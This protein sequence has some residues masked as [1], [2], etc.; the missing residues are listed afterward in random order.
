YITNQPVLGVTEGAGELG[1]S[2]LAAGGLGND[3]KLAVNVPL[4]S[5]AA[6]RVA[7]YNTAIGGFVDAVQPDLSVRENVDGG[8]RTGARAAVLVQPNEQI[9]L[10]PQLV[11]QDVSMNGWNRMDAY[12]ILA[13]PFT[14]TRPAVSL[15]DRQ[16]FT[17]ID[18]PYT[19]RFVL[20]DL[21]AEID[22][23]DV[24]LTQITS[25][26]YRDVEVVRDASALGASVSFSPFGAPEAGYTLDVPLVDATTAE[27][28]TQEIRLAGG[29]ERLD[30]LFGSFY[31]SSERRYGQS[32][33]AK[34]YV[35]VNGPAVTN[36]LRAVTGIPDLVSSGSRPLAGHPHTRG[37]VLLRP[38]LRLRAAR[39]L[40]RGDC[41]RHRPA[42]PDRRPPLERLRRGAHP[43][44]RR[45]LRR[46]PRQRR[47]DVSERDRTAN[48]RQHDVTD[49]TQVNAQVSKGFRL[50]GING[51]LNAPIC[52]EADLATFGSRGPWEDEELW[53]CEA[54]VKS[55]SLGGRG[56]FKRLR[57]LYGHPQPAGDPHGPA[58][59][60][61]ASSST[62]PTRA[63]PGVK[64]ELAA[65]PATFFDFAVSASLADARL[66]STITSTDAD[67]AVGVVSGI[68]TGRRLPSTHRF[69]AAAAAAWR[70]LA[71]G[72]WVGYLSG[73]G[74]LPPSIAAAIS[75]PIFSRASRTGAPTLRMYRSLITVVL[76]PRRSRKTCVP[77]PARAAAVMVVL[78]RSCN[79]TSSSP[80]SFAAARKLRCAVWY[81][82]GTVPFVV[83]A[84]GPSRGIS[85][86]IAS[87]G[88]GRS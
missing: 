52:S 72:G 55:T 40:R 82:M 25:V 71:S 14:T 70:W 87:A 22:F 41:G 77:M 58:P 50:G 2:S 24:V 54:G 47:D 57:L 23:G 37:A 65:Q 35:T 45:P 74:S 29:G 60:R 56:T 30:W 42:Q 19:D 44:V 51:P 6:L 66:Q 48:H 75:A 15:E 68:E 9:S 49:A 36:F 3:A 1:F 64:L 80:A 61:R 16:Q 13:N 43:G 12:N 69:Q 32:A 85:A 33:Y 86:R 67:G 78:R 83:N 88:A 76:W 81:V 10:T 28:V 21:T 18:E 17:Q 62:C 7:A 53:N 46:P 84:N 26:I 20:G 5:A 38:R 8:R 27:G 73:D 39:V 59:A 11:Y 4:G 79:R 31:G 34:D 63:A